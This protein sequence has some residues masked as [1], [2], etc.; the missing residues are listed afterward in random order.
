N[1]G[2]IEATIKEVLSRDQ[3]AKSVEDLKG[4]K[5]QAAGPIIG[6]V[7]KEVKGADAKMVREM[8]L[9]IVQDS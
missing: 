6:Q 1:T 4:G 2:A 3:N 5:Q 9:K 8:I 7:M